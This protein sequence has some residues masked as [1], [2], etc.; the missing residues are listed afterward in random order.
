MNAFAHNSSP[1]KEWRH[2]SGIQLQ[3][4]VW[5]QTPAKEDPTKKGQSLTHLPSD[6]IHW[7][8]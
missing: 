4:T 5:G 2:N 6:F 8:Y 3:W 7:M 1:S